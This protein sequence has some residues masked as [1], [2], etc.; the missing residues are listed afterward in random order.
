MSEQPQRDREEAKSD[1]FKRGSDAIEQVFPGGTKI[2][3]DILE[4]IAPDFATIRS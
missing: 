3:M 1:R 2:T 4:D